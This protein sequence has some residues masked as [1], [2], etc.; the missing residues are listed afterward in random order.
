MRP[1]AKPPQLRLRQGAIFLGGALLYALLVRTVLDF[2]WTPLLLGVVYL[3]A[4][5]AGGRDGGFWAT[6]CVL[7]GWGLGV[8]AVRE[9]ELDVYE[10]GAH[11]A[12]A[13]AGVL[14]AAILARADRVEADAVGLGATALAAGLLLALV[15]H[16]EVF[17]DFGLY[18][19]LLGLV[20][21]LNVMLALSPGRRGGS[22]PSR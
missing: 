20:G 10:P 3:L 2:D 4:A 1:A 11:L 7:L 9:I 15:P 12:G 13:G 22:G 14:V 6:A 21:A 5:L 18:V 17:H 8:V 16:V 19:L